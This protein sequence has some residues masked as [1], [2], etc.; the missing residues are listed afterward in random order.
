MSERSEC[1]I[2]TPEGVVFRLFP[3]GLPTRMLAL[4]IDTLMVSAIISVT[5]ILV[6]LIGLPFGGMTVLGLQVL[7]GFIL[8]LG[9]WIV[10][11]WRWN[12]RTVGKKLLRLRVVDSSGLKL[13]P[14]QLVVRNLLRSVDILPVFYLL[15]SVCAFIDPRGRRLGDIAA[16]TM[17]VQEPVPGQPDLSSVLPDKYNSLRDFPLECAKLREAIKPDES[18]VLLDAL[19]RRETLSP[20]ARCEIYFELAEVVRTKVDL[21]QEALD[22]VSDENFLRNVIDILYKT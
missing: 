6:S 3:A 18:Q 19:I 13:L 10:L 17:V 7:S 22:G 8:G 9:Y 11:E 21:P 15:G 14:R 5:N 1:R 20:D 2:K 12:G 4:I 16:G